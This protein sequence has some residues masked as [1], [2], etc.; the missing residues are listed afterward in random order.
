MEKKPTFKLSLK[1]ETITKLNDDQL[2]KFMG[3]LV[4]VGEN[5]T[6]CWDDS[7][8]SLQNTGSCDNHSCNCPAPVVQQ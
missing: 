2:K 8:N 4:E 7:C 1:K 3:G 5:G 6:S